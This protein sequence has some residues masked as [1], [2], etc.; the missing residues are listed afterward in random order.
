MPHTHVLYVHCEWSQEV[1]V[2]KQDAF[3]PMLHSVSSCTASTLLCNAQM[4]AL[5]CDQGG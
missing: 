5:I 4:A 2:H 3:V 1:Y